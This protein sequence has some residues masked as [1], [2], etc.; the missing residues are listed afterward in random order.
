MWINHK[1]CEKSETRSSFFFFSLSHS[2]C[3]LLKHN[4]YECKFSSNHLHSY[5]MVLGSR[6][7]RTIIQIFICARE[8]KSHVRLRNSCFRVLRLLKRN[9][10]NEKCHTFWQYSFEIVSIPCGIVKFFIACRKMSWW[11]AYIDHCKANKCENMTKTETETHKK[12]FQSHNVN[13]N[14]NKQ[15]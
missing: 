2:S 14:N 9:N 11:I 10:A 12:Q 15:I 3:F 4:N 5:E 13:I 7:F 6:A 1:A 8:K